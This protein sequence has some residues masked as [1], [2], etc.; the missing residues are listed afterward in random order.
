MG[1]FMGPMVGM[2]SVVAVFTWLAVS[3][4]STERRKEREAFYRGEVLR[5]VA[6]SPG[7]NTQTVLEM[8]RQE[9]AGATRRRLE[10]L[11]LGGLVTTGIGFGIVGFFL[12]MVPG[13]PVW[14]VGLVPLFI[15]VA[16]LIYAFVLAPPTAPPPAG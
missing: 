14:T 8:L 13:R 4:W 10:G 15:G 11:K 9:Q 3:G 1:E 12:L 16:L 5:K 7:G 6:E 2:V